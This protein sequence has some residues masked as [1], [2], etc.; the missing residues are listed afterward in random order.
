[1][2]MDTFVDAS[3]I[4]QIGCLVRRVGG[5]RQEWTNQLMCLGR[6][7]MGNLKFQ[8]LLSDQSTGEDA[9]WKNEVDGLF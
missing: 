2:R 5:P 9:R 4:P 8:A 3:L 1:M 6:G 7:L